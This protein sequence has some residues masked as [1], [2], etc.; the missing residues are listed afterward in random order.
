MLESGLV[1][2]SDSYNPE[3]SSIVRGAGGKKRG[4]LRGDLQEYPE[5]SG[6]VPHGTRS[7][8]FLKKQGDFPGHDPGMLS[9]LIFPVY[10]FF[11]TPVR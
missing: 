6:H 10:P 2:G 1:W 11:K 8:R 9:S 7:A 4:L 3:V 5:K